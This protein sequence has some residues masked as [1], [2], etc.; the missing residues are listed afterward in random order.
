M[1]AFVVDASVA[2]KWY[3]DEPWSEAARRLLGEDV[4]LTV[5][6]FFFIETC[7]VL[8]KRQ[9]RKEIS[10]DDVWGIIDSLERLPFDVWR[11]DAL[12][13]QALELAPEYRMSVYDGLYL[14]LADRVRGR[15]AT[16]DRRLVNGVAGPEWATLVLWVD[17][18]PPGNA[19]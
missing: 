15:V 14:A 16:A 3:L 13:R 2:C 12:R 6:E 8:A 10:A 19:D 18:V 1:T 11:D 9:R 5:P 4:Q 17:G 7:N